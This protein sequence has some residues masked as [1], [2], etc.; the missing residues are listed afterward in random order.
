MKSVLKIQVL[1][2]SY[3]LKQK[4]F[5]S[6]ALSKVERWR[7][8]AFHPQ[9]AKVCRRGTTRIWAHLVSDFTVPVCTKDSV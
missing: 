2:C 6:S 5:G 7:G 8:A 9:T 3:R 4:H 1:L